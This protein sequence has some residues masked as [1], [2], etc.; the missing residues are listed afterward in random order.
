MNIVRQVSSVQ[1]ATVYQKVV[2]FKVQLLYTKLY[3][4]FAIR[5][6]PTDYG[7][8]FSLCSS[9]RKLKLRYKMQLN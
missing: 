6:K 2:C 8:T 3:A 5:P 1:G 9:V 4:H 7:R